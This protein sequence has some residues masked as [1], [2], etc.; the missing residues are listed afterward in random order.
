VAQVEADAGPSARAAAHG[1]DEHVVD[2]QQR[3]RRR[4][5][6]LPTLETSERLVLV[7]RLRHGDERLRRL[8]P[9]A[10]FA[11][12]ARAVAFNGSR[13]PHALASRRLHARW[14]A[15]LLAVLRW[16]RRIA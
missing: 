14:F 4:V 7:L 5:A 1:V 12:F 3:C 2:L 16:P 13:G 6:C 15:G 8:P 10:A 9:A 11:L